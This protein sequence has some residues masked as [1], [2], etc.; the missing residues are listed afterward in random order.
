MRLTIKARHLVGTS[1]L[2][3]MLACA[4]AVSAQETGPQDAETQRAGIEDIVV[5][6]NRRTE[7]VQDVPLSITAISS[8]DIESERIQSTSD[9][10]RLVPTITDAGLPAVSGGGLTIRGIRGNDRSAGA[11]PPNG[12]F[13]DGVYFGRPEDGDALL[14]DVERIE[15]LRGPQGTLFGK[16][17]VGGA[18]NVT[19]KAPSQK[20]EAIV[21][22][23][24]GNYN[25]IEGQAAVSGPLTD[26]IAAGISVQSQ[27]S[28][29]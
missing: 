7:N 11:D 22:G 26:T 6:A 19:T 29:G 15:V 20:L 16:N 24:Y 13:V 4:P 21:T 12:L 18:I 8:S 5:T 28:D 3:M 2:G 17:V 1:C 10:G 25:R 23:T 9:L 14:F 27:S